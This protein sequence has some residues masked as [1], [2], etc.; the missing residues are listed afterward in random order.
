[1]KINW[2]QIGMLIASGAVGGAITLSG[3]MVAVQQGWF[4]INDQTNGGVV[5]EQDRSTSGGTAA[6]SDGELTTEEVVKKVLP[7]VVAISGTDS[8]KTIFGTMRQ[9]SGGS[10]FIVRS[11]GLIVTNKHVV[12]SDTAKYTVKLSTGKSYDAVVQARDPGMD[13]AV[14]KINATGLPVV[15]LGDSSKADLGQKVIAIGNTLGEYQNTVTTGIISGLDR[16]VVAS[17][18]A[19]SAE[20]LDGLIQTDAAINPGNSGGPLV[21]LSGQVIGINTAVDTQAQ[22]VGFAIPINSVKSQ[23][24]VV[25]SGGEISRP[26]L[27]VRYIPIDAELA[28]ENDLPVTEGALVASGQTNADVAVQVGGP[29]DLAGIIEGDILVS[30]NGEKITTENGLSAIL[31]KYKPGDVINVTLNRQGQTKTVKVTLGKL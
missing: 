10:G 1:M 9:S 24:K 5:S 12:S 19:G 20:R 21:D 17:D 15:G 16:S 3:W 30:I 18:G 28:Q 8:V 14:I 27:G 13:L 11:D 7:A 6:L 4:I 26:K 29:A 2:K 25:S 31:G 23:I 22:S